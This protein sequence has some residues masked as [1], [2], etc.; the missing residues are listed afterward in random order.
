MGSRAALKNKMTPAASR[1]GYVLQDFEDCT[2]ALAHESGFS[3]YT[4]NALHPNLMR[5]SRG[6]IT[7]FLTDSNIVHNKEI[8]EILTTYIDRPE[9][10]LSYVTP[11]SDLPPDFD[12][13]MNKKISLLVLPLT[14]N[15]LRFHLDNIYYNQKRILSSEQMRQEIQHSNDSVKYV[16]KASQELTGIHDTNKLL[17]LIL[18]KTREVCGADAGSIYVVSWSDHKSK[19]GTIEFRVTQNES[20]TQQFNTFKMPIDDTSIVGNSVLH[21]VAINIPDLYQLDANPEKNQYN[22]RHNRSWDIKTGYQCRSM[23]TLPMFDIEKRVIGVIQLINRKK[24]GVKKL[25]TQH[26]F[27]REVLPFDEKTVDYAKIVAQQSGIALENAL[28][29]EEKEQLFDSFVLA[30]VTAIEQRDPNSSGHAGRVAKMVQKFAEAVTSCKEGTYAGIQFTKDQF[31]ELEFASLLHDFG[32]IG[33]N[34]NILTKQRK[35]Y[36]WQYELLKERFCHARTCVE[37]SALKDLID[38]IRTSGVRGEA[39]ASSSILQAMEESYKALDKLYELIDRSNNNQLL[40]AGDL[41]KFAELAKMRFT[42]VD[43]SEREIVTD[44]EI[45]ALTIADGVLTDGEK[46]LLETHASKTFELLRKIPWLECYAKVPEIAAKHHEKLDGSGYPFHCKGNEIP[47]Q[48]QILCIVDIYD[49]YFNQMKD[50]LKNPEPILGLLRN[51]A[52]EKKIDGELLNIFID[53]KIYE[54]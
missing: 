29:N 42:A 10:A 22:L 38:H 27:D 15:Q 18:K 19:R 17:S 47:L 51:D 7:L 34:E 37:I 20:I 11:A 24:K 43:G 13:L 23:L 25:I 1:T 5:L 21:E 44:S 48:S 54:E 28:L 32:K 33:I 31:K 30:S 4:V 40:S 49:T 36:D 14:L 50:C 2:L 16:L 46:H 45:E 9:V 39:L 6:D 35:L 3:E 8:G 26:D 52:K 53:N 41:E 12:A